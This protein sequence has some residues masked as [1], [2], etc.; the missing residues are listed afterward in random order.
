MHLLDI[1]KCDPKSVH[2]NN[3]SLIPIRT[4]D[5]LF[6]M[7]YPADHVMLN[8]ILNIDSKKCFFVANM[9]T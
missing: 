8:I 4:P 9:A 3:P 2:P 7:D 1:R 6:V 5:V